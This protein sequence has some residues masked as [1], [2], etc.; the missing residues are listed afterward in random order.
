[1]GVKERKEREKAERKEQILSA[2]RSLL[3]S[4]GLEGISVN[5][6]AKLAELGPAT[7]Y[8]YFRGRDEIIVNLTVEG[9]NLLKARVSEAIG[10]AGPFPDGLKKIAAAYLEF[11][12]KQSDYFSVINYFISSPNQVLPAKLKEKVDRRGEEIL[13]LIGELVEKG[14]GSGEFKKVDPI[15]FSLMYWGGLHGM[16]Q[17][18][19]FQQTILRGYRHEDLYIE[20]ADAMIKSLC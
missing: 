18:R 16:I 9:L 14:A 17:L 20:A 12:S 4:R 3:F 6:I 8:T 7:L 5:R 15:K 2:A 1:M 11:S 13:S 19:K 10:K